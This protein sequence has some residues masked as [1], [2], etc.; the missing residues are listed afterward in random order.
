MKSYAEL[1]KQYA[2]RLKG[3]AKYCGMSLGTPLNLSF[4]DKTSTKSNRPGAKE[5]LRQQ[6][7]SLN[8]STRQKLKLELN[9]N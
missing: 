2:P 7:R 6:R 5:K 1:G 4:P 3:L 8:K 9:Y